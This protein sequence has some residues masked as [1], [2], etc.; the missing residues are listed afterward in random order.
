LRE[1]VREAA[2]REGPACIAKLIA[3]RDNP[4]TAVPY[5]IAACNAILDRGFGRPLNGLEIKNATPLRP[6]M[7]GMGMSAEE[8]AL[9]YQLTIEQQA[10]VNG[11]NGDDGD[12]EIIDVTPNPPGANGHDPN[13]EDP[14]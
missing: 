12:G 11:V 14:A 10:N 7:I 8:A 6:R 1:A 3:I 4:R 13:S 5:Q 2:Q 9:Q